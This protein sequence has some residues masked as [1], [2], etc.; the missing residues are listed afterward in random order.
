MGRKEAQLIGTLTDNLISALDPF[1][2]KHELP[3]LKTA[4][5]EGPGAA[6]KIILPHTVKPFVILLFYLVPVVMEVSEPCGESRIIIKAEVLHI[7]DRKQS[8]KRD[9]DLFHRWNNRIREYILFEPGVSRYM[10]Y[11]IPYAV[12]QKQTI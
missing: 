6:Q 7:F 2:G 9:D 3:D 10:G 8:F 5:P 12:Q 4:A 1:W 11:A